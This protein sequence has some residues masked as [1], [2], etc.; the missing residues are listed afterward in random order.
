V[1]S[2]SGPDPKAAIDEQETTYGHDAGRSPTEEIDRSL[3]NRQVTERRVLRYDGDG[4]LRERSTFAAD[5][6]LRTIE[7][8]IYDPNGWIVERRF[9]APD[10]TV[11]NQWRYEYGREAVRVE[12]RNARCDGYDTKVEEL[13]YNGNRLF[14]SGCE[15]WLRH[16]GPA[17]VRNRQHRFDRRGNW[18]ERIDCAGDRRR[19]DPAVDLASVDCPGG[20]L[21]RR[22]I[23][24]FGDAMP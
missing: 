8:P 20:S 24:Y 9:L 6:T 5:G 3:P 7:T 17:P 15:D 22:T 10:R 18:I 12:R 13:D 19:V 14:W 2:T 16:H 1:R 21:A 11:S 4:R 23:T